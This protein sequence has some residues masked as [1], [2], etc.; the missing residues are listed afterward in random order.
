MG[1]RR[2]ADS[3][4]GLRLSSLSSSLLFTSLLHRLF[5]VPLNDNSHTPLSVLLFPFVLCPPS[6]RSFIAFSSLHLPFYFFALLSFFGHFSCSFYSF[7]FVF[8]LNI[9]PIPRFF[10]IFSSALTPSTV[11]QCRRQSSHFSS[12][13]QTNSQLRPTKCLCRTVVP[14]DSYPDRLQS[15]SLFRHCMATGHWYT[16][17]HTSRFQPSRH[18]I[19][20][21]LLSYHG[22]DEEAVTI[23]FFCICQHIMEQHS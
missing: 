13:N 7:F 11:I 3:C 1:V 20:S 18:T 15:V 23:T 2:T 12:V 4:Y 19:C 9:S 22:V 10:L 21:R 5:T 6:N 8:L 16:H 14:V 17:T